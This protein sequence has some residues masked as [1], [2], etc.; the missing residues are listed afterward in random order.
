LQLEAYLESVQGW[1][2]L[3]D[4]LA[5]EFASMEHRGFGNDSDS[6]SVEQ[7]SLSEESLDSSNDADD[8]ETEIAEVL[9]SKQ[10]ID[11]IFS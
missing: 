10:E 7:M 6:H 2:E 3:I 4:S 11:D 1:K 5:D 9:L 8:Y